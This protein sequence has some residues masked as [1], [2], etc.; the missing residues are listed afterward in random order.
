MMAAVKAPGLDW[1]K[2][3]ID[4]KDSYR[5]I[6]KH[7]GGMIE[8]IPNFHT[9]AIIYGNEE[10]KLLE[11]PINFPLTDQYGRIFDVVV[12]PVVMFGPIN[13]DGEE[14][15]LTDELFEETKKYFSEF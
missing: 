10:G 6:S 2:I 3:I 7:V 4:E 11:L 12:G 8:L 5:E 15:E 9:S 1:V 14:T 13:S